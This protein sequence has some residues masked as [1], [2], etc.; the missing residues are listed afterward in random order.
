[1]RGNEYWTLGHPD[2]GSMEAFH[3]VKHDR[4]YGLF[5]SAIIAAWT[6]ALGVGVGWLLFS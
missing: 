1:M 6:F 3:G 4:T 5:F 2:R